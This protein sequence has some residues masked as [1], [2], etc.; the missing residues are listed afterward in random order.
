MHFLT[1]ASGPMDQIQI[2]DLLLRTIIGVNPD[3]RRDR[4]DVLINITIHVDTRRV[5]EDDN[6]NEALNYRSITKR[7]IQ[8][9]ETSQH[10]LI[11]TLANNVAR[12]I[13]TEF[14]VKRVRLRVEKPGALRF[15]RSVAVEIDRSIEDFI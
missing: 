14:D 1:G 8:Y 2:C 10:Y 6:I 3:E 11:E 4:Q 13:L 12:V 7:V 9:V 5:V 15:A